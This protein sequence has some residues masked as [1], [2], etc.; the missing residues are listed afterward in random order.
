MA[1][2]DTGAD[3]CVFP[4]SLATLLGID[5]KAVKPRKVC[6]VGGKCKAYPHTCDV[7]ILNATKKGMVGSTV[8][9]T[10]PNT[11]IDFVP[12]GAHIPGLLGVNQF[13]SRFILEIDYPRQLLHLRNPSSGSS[14]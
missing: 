10:I 11:P 1:L 12:L 14:D 2:V 6:G 8:L 13:L 9:Y 4:A 3:G 7:H 5:L